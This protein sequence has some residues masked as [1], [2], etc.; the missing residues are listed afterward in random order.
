MIKIK[1]I[2]IIIITMIIIIIMIIIMIMIIM[3]LVIFMI[4]KIKIIIMKTMILMIYLGGIR[5][6]IN[7]KAPTLPSSVTI[8]P[9]SEVTI[10]D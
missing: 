10:D 2:M 6:G 1:I 5:P 4:F 8:T 9:M 3:M 7:G